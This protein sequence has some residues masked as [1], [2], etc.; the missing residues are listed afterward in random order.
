VNPGEQYYSDITSKCYTCHSHCDVCFGSIY[1]ETLFD[2]SVCKAG[3][4]MHN[5]I[6]E[7]NCPTG[8][9]EG[10]LVCTADTLKDS[11]V[12]HYGGFLK[13]SNTVEDKVG[14]RLAYLGTS[15]VVLPP[16]AGPNDPIFSRFAGLYF[17]GTSV[18]VLPPNTATTASVILNQVHTVE[19]T[20]RANHSG[21]DTYLMSKSS[22]DKTQL[23]F[24]YGI[25]KDRKLFVTMRMPSVYK[26]GVTGV[27]AGTKD[28]TVVLGDAGVF[29]LA[30]QWRSLVFTVVLDGT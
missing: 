20:L 15:D 2:C 14:K 21:T 10:S 6:C 11:L 29:P 22:A 26:A 4:F 24:A 27:D 8:Y 1:R 16:E 23:T 28:K 3:Y 12:L 7:D 5:K 13:F 18:L 19:F 9:A 17:S 30:D 25:D